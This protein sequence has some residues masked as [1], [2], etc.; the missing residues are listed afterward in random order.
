MIIKMLQRL[1]NRMEKMQEAFHTDNTSTKDKEEINKKQAEMNNKQLLKL[2]TLQK[3]PI[4][5]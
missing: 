3:K 2:K 4:A 1:E 5:E